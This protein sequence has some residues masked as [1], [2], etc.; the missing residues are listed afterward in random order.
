MKIRL[1]G[2]RVRVEGLRGSDPGILRVWHIQ[3]GLRCA[4]S[5][6]ESGW[7]AEFGV[8]FSFFH[9]VV[10]IVTRLLAIKA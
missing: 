7:A 10:F 4:L 2:L 3:L 5:G 9:A 1:G 8:V 6:L